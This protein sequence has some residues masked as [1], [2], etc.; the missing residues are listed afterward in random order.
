MENIEHPDVANDTKTNISDKSDTKDNINDSKD[1]KEDKSNAKDEDVNKK[2]LDGTYDDHINDDK[3]A[4]GQEFGFKASSPA[5]DKDAKNHEDEDEDEEK[6][7]LAEEVKQY[8]EKIKVG[9]STPNITIDKTD[10]EGADSKEVDK[11]PGERMGVMDDDDH[12]PDDMGM[13]PDVASHHHHARRHGKD[14]TP[15]TR[16]NI[17]EATQG[18][19]LV[20]NLLCQTQC[21]KRV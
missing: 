20:C 8:S 12:V 9:T 5:S 13:I 1:N 19:F 3:R 17:K 14:K 18:T 2:N 21:Q 15:I 11:P 16:Q 10:V 4:D 6:R 7:L